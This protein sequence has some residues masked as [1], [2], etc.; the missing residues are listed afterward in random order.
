MNFARNERID[1]GCDHFIQALLTAAAAHNRDAFRLLGTVAKR[2]I[3]T[4]KP[5]FQ[6]SIEF[7]E[8]HAS[9]NT[10]VR[11]IFVGRERGF[12]GYIEGF[13]NQRVVTVRRMPVER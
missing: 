2:P 9:A 5:C 7:I 11:S 8:C 13:G 4:R 6:S 10:T 3:R 1:V 12:D